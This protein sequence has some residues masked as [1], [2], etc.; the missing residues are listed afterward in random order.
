MQNVIIFLLAVVFTPFISFPVHSQ[1]AKSA[2][3]TLVDTQGNVIGR[4]LLTETANG[5]RIQARIREFKSLASQNQRGQHGF[6][7]KE[8]GKC[9]SPDFKSAGSIFNP[10]KKSHGLL[11]PNGPKAGNLVN[12]WIEADGSADYDITSN[13]ITL[14]PGERSVFDKDG[15]AFV[16]HENPDDYHTDPE[17]NTGNRIAC[18]VI[19]PEEP[20][21]EKK[22]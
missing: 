17:G 20:T 19:T 9:D 12:I 2:T 11:D 15:S 10:T 6:H 3:A 8:V 18:G 4:V 14:S 1:E 21:S 22:K 16:I 5:V 7:V 13:L